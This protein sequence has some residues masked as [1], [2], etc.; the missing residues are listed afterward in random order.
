MTG[1]FDRYKNDFNK[2]LQDGLLLLNSIQYECEPNLFMEKLKKEEGV[3][4]KIYLSKIP[5]FKDKYQSWYSESIELIRILLPNRL[6]D[7]IRYYERPKVRKEV[8]YMTYVIED[9]LQDLVVKDSYGITKVS[10]SSAIPKFT[11]QYR[12]LE[13]IK[14]RFISSLFD[15]KQL[16]QADIFDSEIDEAKE[17]NKKGFTRAAGVICGVI[18][19]KHLAEICERHKIAIRKKKPTLS[20]FHQTLKD[21]GIIET[22]TWRFIQHLAD[23]RNNCSHKTENEPTRE[24][25]AELINGTDKIIKSVF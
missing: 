23:L 4:P 7:F 1:N 12:I 11:Q 5:T 25:V 10:K 18:L 13:S 22:E 24:Q 15:I 14:G 8:D 3:D 21:N 20:D 17:L 19:E 2:L 6:S 9:Y 16:T